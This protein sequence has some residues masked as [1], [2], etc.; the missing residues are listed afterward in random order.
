M[1]LNII[2]LVLR[3]IISVISDLI[4]FCTCFNIDFIRHQKNITS[5]FLLQ[6]V[7]IWGIIKCY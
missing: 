5:S 1:L 3:V 7:K 2:Y 6:N 4:I